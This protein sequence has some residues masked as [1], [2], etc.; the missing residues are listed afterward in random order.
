MATTLRPPTDNFMEE[1][2]SVKDE[3]QK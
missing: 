2:D 3:N 1:S